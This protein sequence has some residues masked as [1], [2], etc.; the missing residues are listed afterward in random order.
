[1][2]TNLGWEF[3]KG[4]FKNI[5]YNNLSNPNNETITNEKIERLLHQN[6]IFLTNEKDEMIGN[7]HFKATTTYPGLL[8]GSGYLHELPDVKGQL[9]LGFDFDYTTGLPI[10][11]GSS[12]K[13]VLRS[14]FQ[15]KEYIK[16]ILKDENID[17][18]E[19][20]KE[21]FDNNDIFF[22]A[23]IIKIQNTLL[24]DDY[25]APHKEITKDPIPL[26]FLKVAPNV[27]FRFDF[28]LSDGIISKEQKR[29]LF[30]T[31]LEDLGVGAKTNVGYGK[32]YIPITKSD[33]P[34]ENYKKP[35]Q[36]LFKKLK[37]LN[38][39]NE[40]KK[41]YFEIF[42]KKF[43]NEDKNGKWMK[44]ITNLLMN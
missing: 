29:E 20:E 21:I 31:I 1:M 8:L 33:N 16:E 11:R 38:L 2:A 42:Q 43:A 30:K 10:I 24:A 39:S 7:I 32:F 44:K 5:D 19:L 23:Q 3:Y 17:I 41:E 25:L 15:E 26:R 35:N 6:Q 14:A 34:I 9:I 12:I 40:K 37:E 13:G 18:S 36:D 4:Y 28:E 27:T 22:D